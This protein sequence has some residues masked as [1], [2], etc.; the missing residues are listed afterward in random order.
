M[1]HSVQTYTTEEQGRMILQATDTLLNKRYLHELS[2][3]P[4]QPV[5]SLWKPIHY[6]L[7]HIE[8]IVYDLEEDTYEKLS[9]VLTTLHALQSKAVL[10][11]Q[12]D[13]TTVNVYAGIVAEDVTSA[14]S[15][16]HMSMKGAFPGSSLTSL[17][18]RDIQSTIRKTIE[19]EE[20]SRPV[21][22][23]VSGLPTLK[24]ETTS[25]Y[26]QGLEK[27]IEAMHGRSFSSLFIA[28]PIS[29]N[30]LQKVKSGY[31]EVGTLLS[32]FETMN[33]TMSQS[34]ARGTSETLTKS[35]GETIGTSLS[36]TITTTNSTSEAKVTGSSKKQTSGTLAIT[37]AKLTAAV[38][39]GLLANPATA[40]IG[41]VV[42]GAIGLGSAFI[43]T[44]S[45]SETKTKSSSIAT[46]ET[47]SQNYSKNRSSSRAKGT[48][49]TVTDTT[50]LQ[51][52]QTN[53]RV[54]SIL[55]R[56]NQQ[57]ERLDASENYGMW[58][59]AAYFLSPDAETVH[60]AASTYQSLIRGEDSYLENS[61]TNVWY[62][63]ID[64]ETNESY[65]H[66]IRAI[67]AW[68]HPLFSVPN[69]PLVV[70]AGTLI[71]TKELAVAYGL[72]R[73]SITGLPVIEMAEFG[74]DVRTMESDS[75][76]R[77]IRLGS[78]YHMGQVEREPIVLD[79]DRLAMHTFI[80][81]TTGSGK[82]N[83]IYH[84]LNEIRQQGIPFLVIEPAK[85]EYR[86]V[87]GGHRDVSVFGT[88]V[89]D[90]PLLKINPFYFPPTIHVLEH[91][92]Q[93][94]EIFNASWPMYAAM[95]A[96]LKEAVERAYVACGWNLEHS[97]SY[98]AQLTNE[99]PRY[100]TLQEVVDAL[101]DVIDASD[102]SEEVKGNYTG[103]LITRVRSLQNGLAGQILVSDEIPSDLLFD[104]SCII[105]LSRVASSETKSLLMGILFMRLKEYRMH[106][107]TERKRAGEQAMNVPLQ[108]V[109]VLEEAHHL[110][111]RVE[112]SGEGSQLQAQSVEMI[113]NGIAEMRTYGEGFIIADQSPNLLDPSVIRNTNTKLIM[114]LPE[115]QDRTDV[116]QAAALTQ[117]QI[118]EIPKLERGVAVIYQNDW[119]QPV[120][121]KI[122]Y[123]DAS[124][125]RADDY[126]Y[127]A[128]AR[129]KQLRQEKTEVVQ[130][131]FEKKSHE[132][133]E[134]AQRLVYQSKLSDALKA[135]Y[136][137]KTDDPYEIAVFLYHY[138]NGQEAVIYA[139][140]DDAQLRR[141]LDY[142]V[143]HTVRSH[144]HKI[145]GSLL[146]VHDEALFHTWYDIQREKEEDEWLETLERCSAK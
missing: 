36:K 146:Y 64:G 62:P 137:N 81:G 83:T 69:D 61:A 44:Q 9:T 11:L 28:D 94:I 142:H 95:P 59:F 65:E 133:N 20:G 107:A 53:F 41:A 19:P 6:R 46:G 66:V 134:L 73:K 135:W 86:H 140:A 42:A 141:W 17:R 100:P 122:D 72:P 67:E 138:L 33:G 130:G 16:L 101:R 74:R 48:S 68:E 119:L 99:P 145:I 125:H 126:T 117:A 7:F 60:V 37:G 21:I 116:G 15:A 131:C 31:E 112:R 38:G 2:R 75:K 45:K 50:S 52:E 58:N 88:N 34:E 91:I 121:G 1:D 85:G 84:L 26:I 54:R 111:K 90:A 55:E 136:R 114:R 104:A 139:G 56:T 77:T 78:I 82:S 24:E 120:L 103:S 79:V 115:G 106:Q 25:S 12:S 144:Y 51:L 143:S 87:F 13:G 109:T 127:D 49:E 98:E 63:K 113:T 80:T 89:A 123:F 10:F 40:G 105:D 71:H 110:L 39:A 43:P 93:L 18:G 96:V 5:Q 22:S 132:A 35:V 4:A 23:S 128:R 124:T 108:H 30:A 8:K 92:D 102:Y 118:D 70:D 76:A 27:F 3:I 14:A 97:F 57:L 129:M 47:V 32:P 29:S